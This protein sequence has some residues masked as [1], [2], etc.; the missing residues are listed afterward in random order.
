MNCNIFR[1][2]SYGIIVE[3][4]NNYIK[5]NRIAN[6]YNYGINIT[7][8]SNTVIYNEIAT[9]GGPDYNNY[10]YTFGD[11][12]NL[13]SGIVIGGSGS[14]NLIEQNKIRMY[15][16][17][18]IEIDGPSN[19]NNI[20]VENE[21]NKCITN[22]TD[23]GTETHFLIIK[24]PEDGALYTG[25]TPLT[26][27]GYYS[28]TE[29]FQ[30]IEDGIFPSDWSLSGNGT[31]YD[32][33]VIDEKTDKDGLNHKKILYTYTGEGVSPEINVTRDFGQNIVSG[34]IEFWVLRNGD[35]D[36]TADF[37]F[38]GPTGTL[39]SIMLKSGN[40]YFR[41]NLTLN[42]TT[43]LFEDDCWYRLSIDF[44]E[45]G[46]YA[47]LGAH[48]YKFRI[49][50]SSG[51]GLL[52][53]SNNADYFTNDN[54]SGIRITV[55]GGSSSNMT[56]YS[57]AFGYSWHP[58]YEIG[59]NMYEGM[60][61]S[62]AIQLGYKDWTWMGYSLNGEN[63]IELPSFGDVIIPLPNTL[64]EQ[65][66]QLFANNSLDNQTFSPIIHFTYNFDRKIN[67]LSHYENGAL[68]AENTII[69]GGL[70]KLEPVYNLNITITYN[71]EKP[72]GIYTYTN[73][74]IYYR[75]NQGSW[76]G[77]FVS[78][79]NFGTHK[80]IYILDKINYDLGDTV[81]YYLK[82]QQYE[83]SGKFL[84]QYFWTQEGLYYF[85]SEAQAHPF[86]K[87]VSPIP[88]QLTLDYSFFYEAERTEEIGTRNK[89]AHP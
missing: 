58:G 10:Y 26:A 15:P 28:G 71:T 27:F 1:T 55:Q 37:A 50:N 41:D 25:S 8:D 46:S 21:F 30:D 7:G 31:G 2:S 45:D 17:Y 24:I 35:N 52:Y 70:A 20:I 79:S 61:I 6:A 87:K 64:G 59:D 22:I 4:D 19:Q 67:I 72:L 60:F 18:G 82:F 57:D 78:G 48:Q 40:F 32:S 9:F 29:G 81:D 85:E 86:H 53:E 5:N 84:Q 75:I 65:T 69:K 38:L 56:I 42:D 62:P 68:V 16:E 12:I 47:G 74:S 80:F 14:N 44:S 39:F 66:L 49:Y 54:C 3:G 36:G 43:V 77:P 76:M 33:K 83:V 34:T 11:A 88:Y 51:D 89:W 63:A 73:A 23:S 13:S